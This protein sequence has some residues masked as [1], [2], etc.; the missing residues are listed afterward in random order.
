M[1]ELFSIQNNVKY[2]NFKACLMYLDKIGKQKYGPHF[3]IRKEDAEIIYKLLIYAIGDEENC[4]KH[5]F[6]INKG[7]LLLGPVGC[8]K[9]SLMTIIKPF[10]SPD[11]QLIIKS[12]REITF[13]FINQGYPVILK[14]GKS[15]KVYCF[16][17][18]GI[19]K[20]QKHFGNECNTMGE[21][22]LF[23]Y[24]IFTQ[25]KI[26]THGTTNL[27]A[28]E[29]EVLYGQR[30]R[31]RLREMYNLIAFDKSIPDKRK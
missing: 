7:I 20:N 1:E 21:I 5:N 12:T 16:D 29:L 3:K 28:E 6:S 14:Y 9:T 13:E 22:L 17:D 26:P 15:L 10:F 19:E 11:R 2:Y 25:M 27:N 30:V 4:F 8:G 24:E 31:S 23:R 18:L